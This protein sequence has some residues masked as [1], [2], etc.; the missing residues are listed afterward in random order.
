MVLHCVNIFLPSYN[1]SHAQNELRLIQGLIGRI[2][3]IIKSF[4]EDEYFKQR[5]E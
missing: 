5:N 3:D 4:N 2:G 1:S